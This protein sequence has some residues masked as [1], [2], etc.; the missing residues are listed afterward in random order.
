[1]AR[2][3]GAWVDLEASG[4]SISNNAFVQADDAA[5]DLSSYSDKEH[6]QF[7]LEAAYASA[8][9]ANTLIELHHV[10]QDLFGGANDGR[11]PS[12]NNLGGILA[13]V[14]VDNTTSTQRWRFD[15]LLGPA[16]SK[17][18]LRNNGTGQTISSGWKLRARA[19]SIA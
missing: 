12:A 11:D 17:Y 8:P 1:M 18:W 3:Y 5:L 4:A 9:T 6:I 14:L 16:H 13:G 15:V 7:E 19:F 2:S 10:A